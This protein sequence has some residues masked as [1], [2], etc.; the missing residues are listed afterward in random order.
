MEIS[1]IV[2]KNILLS[3][4]HAILSRWHLQVGLERKRHFIFSS[5]CCE[6]TSS[7]ELF[8]LHCKARKGAGYKVGCE[9]VAWQR[10]KEMLQ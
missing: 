1:R 10:H 9:I 6:V 4:L 8:A 7:Q 5:F 3:D 2:D